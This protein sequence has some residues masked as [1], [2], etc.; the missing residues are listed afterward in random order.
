[1]HFCLPP[2]LTP[3]PPSFSLHLS[4]LP[5]LPS[6][7]T[8]LPSPVTPPPSPFSSHSSPFTCHSSPLSLHLPLSHISPVELLK[9]EATVVLLL[10]LSDCIPQQLQNI[11][12]ILLVHHLLH[13]HTRKMERQV[14]ASAGTV[15]WL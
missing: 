14:H 10:N 6:R 9:A 8:P 4:L 11:I 12:H 2:S 3:S 5:P 15:Q 7:L 13:S 1:M